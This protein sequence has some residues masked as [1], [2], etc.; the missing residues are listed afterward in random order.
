MDGRTLGCGFRGE[1][2][3]KKIQNYNYSHIHNKGLSPNKTLIIHNK[4]LEI[5]CCK[6]MLEGFF[7]LASPPNFVIILYFTLVICWHKHYMYNII[8]M[9]FSLLTFNFC[10]ITQVMFVSLLLAKAHC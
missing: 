9:C 6:N 10:T 8:P 2:L 4:G 3:I 1:A 7:S 5:Q